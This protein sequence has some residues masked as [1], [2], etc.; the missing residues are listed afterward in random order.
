M[1]SLVAI[2]ALFA[3]GCCPC[4]HLT[5]STADSVRVE[6]RERIVKVRDTVEVYLPAERVE[7]ITADT[8]SRIETSAAVS[9]ASVRDGRLHHA[10]WNKQQPLGV[11]VELE[12]RVEDITREHITTV[13][14]IVEVPAE[15]TWWQ[16]TQ[17][18]GFWALLAV[19]GLFCLA[20][21]KFNKIL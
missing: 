16:Q 9:T 15:L 19:F 17:M 14:N 7:N 10:L 12:T 21:T 2:L 4:K 13:R 3:V 8:T 20:K 5:T 18:R 11:A 6:V 1:R